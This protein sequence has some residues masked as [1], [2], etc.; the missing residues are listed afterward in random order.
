MGKDTL[1]RRAL[2]ALPDFE[3]AITAT[4][5]PRRPGERAGVS[6][7]F[8]SAAQFE[9]KKSKDELLEWATVHGYMYGTPKKSVDEIIAAGKNVILAVDVQG[10]LT[11][12]KKMREAV[13]IFVAPPSLEELER[14]LRRRKTEDKKE[15]TARIEAAKKEIELSSLYDYVMVNRDVSQATNEL[16]NVIKLV[17]SK[18]EG[19]QPH[20]C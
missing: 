17:L 4:T 12:K 11:I 14:R 18:V 5:R 15:I 1:I 10:A 7:Y 3:R 19:S 6:Y 8:V 2:K 9:G 13:L 16:L 20:N